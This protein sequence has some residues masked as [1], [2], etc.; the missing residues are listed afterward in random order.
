MNIFKVSYISLLLPLAVLTGCS[1]EDLSKGVGSPTDPDAITFYAQAF[2]STQ[3][4][5]GSRS[6]GV[7]DVL[8]EPL[9][10][11]D[12]DNIQTLYL[13]T[14]VA[15][16]IGF[17]PGDILEDAPVQSRGNQIETADALAEFHNN[18]IVR[19]V[20]SEN[21]KEYI[22]WSATKPFSA[23]NMI[24]VTDRTEYWPGNEQLSFF[25]VSPKSQFEKLV[26]VNS[27]NNIL[28]FSY[29]AQKGRD[30]LDAEAQPDLL[31]A[32]SMCNKAS[33]IEGK[34][35]LKFHHA[36]SAVKFAVRD[37]LGGEIETI[38]IA[39]IRSSGDC[40]YTYDQDNNEGVF[41]WS[42]Q[43]GKE[44][45]TQNFNYK[46]D[47][48]IV[49][50]ADET[51][52]IV[53]NDGMPA[54]TF[55]LIPQQI[56]DDAEVV[57]T[58]TRNNVVAPLPSRI[59]VRG[60]IKGNNITEWKPGHEYIYTIS[61][62]KDNWVYV[63]NATGNHSGSSHN[64]D[65]NSIYVYSPSQKEYDTYGENAYFKV[66]SYRYRA[67]NQTVREIL[68]WSA[69]HGDG[70][71]YRISIPEGQAGHETAQYLTA[72]EWINDPA[73]LKGSGSF[74]PEQHNLTFAD[75]H[76][77][78]N[79]LGD[80]WMQEQ[81]AYSGNSESNPWDLSTFGG[82]TSRNTANTYV[83][84]RE[85]WY[86]FP[87]VYGNAVKNGVDNP[88]S[89]K[90]N[91]TVVTGNSYLRTFTDYKGNNITQPY[92]P[93]AQAVSAGVVWSDVYNA[94]SDVR[95]KTINGTKMIMFK[96]NKFNLQQ[97]N[98]VIALYDGSGT[99]VW[100][101]QIWFTEHWLNPA[102]GMSHNFDNNGAAFNYERVIANGRRNRGD[103]PV[104]VPTAGP[105]S[106]K[107]SYR[108]YVAP[109]NVGW[110]DSK[111]LDYLQRPG[112]MSFVQYMP[113]GT[114]LSGHT[115]NLPIMQKG[116]FIEYKYGNNTYYQFGRKDPIVGFVNHE[117]EVKRNFGPKQYELGSQPQSI[118][119]SIQNPQMLYCNGTADDWNS[120]HYLNLWNNNKDAAYAYPSGTDVQLCSHQYYFH[121]L[122]TVYDPCPPGYMVP[123]IAVFKMIGTANNGL[124]NNINS[125]NGNLSTL[126]GTLLDTYTFKIRT[127]NVLTD[128]TAIW[129]T[130]TGNRWYTGTRPTLAPAGGNFN[131]QIVYL[132]S[133]NPLGGNGQNENQKSSGYGL[134]LGLDKS[135]GDAGD[136]YCICTLFGGRRTMARPVRPIRENYK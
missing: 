122:K 97:G 125:N 95:L 68:P 81:P 98:T 23:D 48:R 110:C 124:Y 5:T 29:T 83:V 13:H 49:D 130:S 85:G 52:D 69:S 15:D 82:Q 123:P 136:Q 62:S 11:S 102:N 20:K 1:D 92:I 10:L 74:T 72:A 107:A 96:A 38:S 94:L 58:L 55:V 86:C 18:F 59:T 129:L 100:S 7:E 104:Q 115:A 50:P 87:L 79:W 56:P 9:E 41:S 84:D 60:K 116:E 2:G 61:T 133:S 14:Y 77:M 66:T 118:A 54:K 134:A 99:V 101:W 25:A 67:N 78:T 17:D 45:Y 36:L 70:R 64:V 8:Y 12:R 43:S 119:H 21:S 26:N 80:E 76:I 131:P 63:F 31:I 65:G 3:A 117:N 6:G 53:L 128:E 93:V 88:D 16:R 126:N 121:S 103:L 51:M 40:T 46:V 75:H 73:G 91:G 132:W 108:Y 89:Y 19:A 44:T 33:S 112:E 111:S 42:N 22:G 135:G 114:A 30:N 34:A 37:V 32:T 47:D 24:W 71:Q 4:K 120:S 90:F 109:Y 39:G 113:D 28:S 105:S 57:I 106:A 127:Q 27:E 35:P